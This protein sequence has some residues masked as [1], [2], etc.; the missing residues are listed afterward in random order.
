MDRLTHAYTRQPPLDW[1]I[2]R[3]TLWANVRGGFTV[4]APTVIPL[5]CSDLKN[6][7]QG[8]RFIFSVVDE[9]LYLRM[10]RSDK[11][12]PISVPD[13]L[14]EPLIMTSSGFRSSFQPLVSMWRVPHSHCFHKLTSE[15]QQLMRTHSFCDITEE[16][17]NYGNTLS[18]PS[19]C[20]ACLN[21][22]YKLKNSQPKQLKIEQIIFIYNLFETVTSIRKIVAT[23]FFYNHPAMLFF[24][25]TWQAEWE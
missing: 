18:V 6:A 10:C 8:W 23:H 19:I 5:I 20:S 15:Q 16:F 9:P 21:Y 22:S 17:H 1:L 25:S 14:H 11:S 24:L 7:R 4:S 12:G 2:R 3:S 13:G